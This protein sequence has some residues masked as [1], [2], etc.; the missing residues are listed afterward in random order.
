MIVVTGG[1]GFIGSHLADRLVRDGHRV[2]ILDDYSSGAPNNL[3]SVKK[4]AELIEGDIRD[5]RV[6]REAMTGAEIV[7]HQAA[8]CSVPR[9]IEYPEETNDVNITGTLNVLRAAKAA[10]VKRVVFAS[11]SSVYGSNPA[12]RKKEDMPTYPSSPYAISK[13]AGEHYCKVFHHIYGLETV[14]LRY[15][16]VFGP[17]QS[18]LSPYS[19]VIPRFINGLLEN[20]PLTIYGDGE[21]S[22]DFTYVQ[23]VV[24][25]NVLVMKSVVEGEAIN[26]ACGQSATINELASHLTQLMGAKPQIVYTSPRE[27]DVLHSLADVS[28]ARAT[29]GY[30]PETS[31]AEGLRQTLAYTRNNLDGCT[32]EI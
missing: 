12:M 6:L 27:G 10:G 15:F 32:S 3:V 30:V 16:N 17:R 20:K 25:A 9:S 4:D 7:F 31:L 2:R 5:P 13:L 23:N 8:R 21:Q 1:A 22:R 28:K 14:T 29:L 18:W 24:E 19:A 11:S 26:I